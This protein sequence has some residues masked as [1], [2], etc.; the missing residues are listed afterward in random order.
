MSKKQHAYTNSHSM[1]HDTHVV[2]SHCH[3][4]ITHKQILL[5]T[6]FLIQYHTMISIAATFIKLNFTH[7]S[8]KCIH[9][10]ES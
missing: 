2:L 1:T 9:E 6:M 4:L 10:Q 7:K 8:C 3:S 5:D